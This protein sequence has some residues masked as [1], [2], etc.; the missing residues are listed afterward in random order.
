MRQEPEYAKV[1]PGKIF[2]YL[3]SGKPILGIGQEDGAAAL[4]L[5]DAGAGKMFDW[6]KR[7][8]LLEFIDDKHNSK[9][10]IEKYNR[11]VLTAGLVELLDKTTKK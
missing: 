6:D 7:D 1:L 2:E 3:A 8:E 9:K 11:R 4:I 10:N 5:K